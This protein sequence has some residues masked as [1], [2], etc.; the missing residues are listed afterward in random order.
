MHS[1]AGFDFGTANCAMGVMKDGKPALLDLPQHGHYLSSTLYA[2]QADMISGWLYRQL[3]AQGIEKQYQD[4]RYQ[5]L[6]G[7][8]QA[9][10]EGKLDGYEDELYFG[11]EAL[12]KYLSDPADCYYIRS[13][14]SFLGVSG[15]TPRQQQVVEDIST[16]IMW[17]MRE[18]TRKTGDCLIQKVVIGRPV[19]FQGFDSDKSNRQAIE[20]LTRAAGYAGF[21]QVEFLYEPI[22]AGLNYQQQ[23]QEETQVLV[24]D[25]GGG[26]SDVS[27]LTMGPAYLDHHRH[28]DQILGFSGERVGGNDFDIALNART[29]MPALGAGL[30]AP[31]GRPIP[32]SPF[33]DAA[34]VNQLSAQTRFYSNDTRK[35]LTDLRRQPGLEKLSRLLFLQTE[36]MTFQLSATAEQAKIALSQRD[37]VSVDLS[38]I[39]D[40][41]N[42]E[43]LQQQFV[44]AAER[45]L[46]RIA[47][48]IDE[49]MAQADTR[50]D[51]LFL[52]GGSANSPFIRE[53]LKVRYQLPLVSGDNFGSVT[54]GLTLWADR[55]FS[56]DG[57]EP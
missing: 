49:V 15:V 47:R 23:L 26:T 43:V 14:K 10:K 6:S 29:L 11:Q 1:V 38:F 5:T 24:I 42:V 36:Q 31:N 57:I 56:S 21:K 19:N 48:L 40:G 2:P 28:D 3:K 18:Q 41:L 34:S 35:L 30:I 39:E 45:L 4:A 37:S 27:M 13:P 9:L 32:K 8:L 44:H 20:V 7:S 22:A 52:T 55:I 46:T 12:A 25:I 16:S 54:S 51:V 33:Y 17:H 53:F 50:P